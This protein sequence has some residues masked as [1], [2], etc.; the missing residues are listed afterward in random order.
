MD[1]Q[2]IQI[3]ARVAALQNLS[4]VGVE[5]GLTPGTISK[6]VQALEDELSVRLFERTTR[7]IRITDEGQRLL[8]HVQAILD[9]LEK[10]RATVADTA[11]NPKGKLKVVASQAIGASHVAP[12]VLGFLRV[13]PDI[14]VQL[15]LTDRTVHLQDEGYDVAVHLGTLED[16]ALIAKRLAA[17]RL[18]LVAA[19]HYLAERGLPSAAD[20][21]A[22]HVCLPLGDTW[23][24]TLVRD[25]VETGV[26]LN[27]RLRSDNA[28]VVRAAAIAGHG[29]ARLSELHAASDIAA[30]RLVRVLEDYD[31]GGHAG[32]WALYPNGKHVLPRLRVF[33]DYIAE[34][35]RDVRFRN[36]VQTGT[37]VATVL[38]LSR[39]A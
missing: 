37:D 21:L 39:G 12:A 29:I 8:V 1:I 7:S 5:L 24:W 11:G 34:C 3:F 4:A 27:G 38:P 18:I 14:E 6:R 17:D 36:A 22:A 35:F 10:A 15:D 13:Y 26:R 32:I 16:S 19:P 30:G 20:G 9:E 2:D 25:R 33:L 23:T 31:A 28:D